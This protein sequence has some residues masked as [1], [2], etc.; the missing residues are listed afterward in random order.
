MLRWIMEL[1]YDKDE[2]ERYG[3]INRVLLGSLT[4]GK[5][6]KQEFFRDRQFALSI[7][8]PIYRDAFG[9][10]F[11][12]NGEPKTLK[13]IGEKYK[14]PASMVRG[15]IME[16]F[17]ALNDPCIKDLLIRCTDDSIGYYG[18]DIQKF[19]YDYLKALRDDIVLKEA[20]ERSSRFD[21]MPADYK[22]AEVYLRSALLQRFGEVF[23]LPINWK[24]EKKASWR[25]RTIDEVLTFSLYDEKEYAQIADQIHSAGLKF[26]C[27]MD[28]YKN[29]ENHCISGIVDFGLEEFSNKFH[30]GYTKNKEL[31]EIL[32]QRVDDCG[33][34]ART[35][36][37]LKNQDKR[38]FL[39]IVKT[40]ESELSKMKDMTNFSVYEVYKKAADSGLGLCPDYKKSVTWQDELLELYTRVVVQ[41]SG[42]ATKEEFSTINNTSVA[43]IPG[44]ALRLS[45]G[46]KRKNINTIGELIS[47]SEKELGEMPNLGKIGIQEIKAALSDYSLSLRPNDLTREEWLAELSSRA[48]AESVQSNE[49]ADD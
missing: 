38:I 32:E 1:Y 23:K 47:Y 16:A 46:L 7:L 48:N 14:L 13:E 49:L 25:D 42:L 10:Y 34:T 20:V 29:W 11:G 19:D 2:H 5:E 18:V 30:L 39:D 8:S 45:N 43:D 31:K 40:K 6:E 36:S 15:L 3:N 12:L 22:Q 4:I 24:E 44:L 37:A 28:Y 35:S 33:F 41:K 27:E 17:L 9:M 21:S 26:Y